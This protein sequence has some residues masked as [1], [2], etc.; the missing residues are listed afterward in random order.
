VRGTGLLQAAVLRDGIDARAAIGALQAR[1]LLVSIAGG[2]ALRFSPPL[3]V[4]PSE[5]D[6]ALAMLDTTLGELSAP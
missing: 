6:E 1:G 4:K 2:Q 5:I 3:V